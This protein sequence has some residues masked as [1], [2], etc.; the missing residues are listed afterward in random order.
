VSNRDFPHSYRPGPGPEG[1]SGGPAGRGSSFPPPPGA[2]DGY[3]RAS[4]AGGRGFGGLG[5]YGRSSGGGRSGG[6]HSARPGRGAPRGSGRLL[7]RGGPAAAEGRRGGVREDFYSPRRGAP[8]PGDGSVRGGDARGRPG[9]TRGGSSRFGTGVRDIRDELRERLRR[10]GVS[11]DWDEPGR[12]RPPRRGAAGGGGGDWDGPGG[13]EP[14]RKGSWWRHWTWKKALTVAA[15]AFGVFIILAA[16]GVAYAYSKTPIPDVQQSVNAQ[17]SKV[18]YSD[19]KTLVGQFGSTNRVILQYSQIPA[20]MVNAVV[21]AE[22]KNFWH[23]GGISPTGI[24]RAAY[25]DLTS[26]GGNLQGGSTITQQLVRNYYENIGT[27]QTLS[28]KIKEIFV[29]EKLAQ[30]KSKQWILQQYLNTVLL[31][32]NVYGVGAAAQYYFGLAPDQ[33]SKI[34]PAQAA[35]IAALIQ[36]PNG[37]SPNPK[38]GA[39]Y[40]GLVYR[41]RYVLGAMR[42]MGTLSPQEYALAA[43]K[44][45]AVVPPPN[46]TWNGYR[47]YIM[48]A[49]QNELLNTYNYSQQRINNGGLHIVTTVSKPLMGRL[50]GQVRAAETLM[51]RCTP[52]GILAGQAPAPCKGLPGYV[53]AGA[54]LED[55][56]N[57]AIL[58]WYGGPNYNKKGCHCQYDNALQS[59]NQVGSSFKTYVLATAVAQ[60]MSVQ[61]SILDGD[62][63]LWIP[64]DSQ[65]A[66]F[67]KPGGQAPGPGYYEVVND[68]SGN[69]SFGGVHV[70]LATAASLN[71]AY[72]DLWHRVA[73]N[74]TTGRHPVTDMAKA[75][76]VDVVASG[77]VGG[78]RP[79]QDEAGIALGQASLTV[80]EQATTIATLA[81]NGLY[82]SPHVIK[83]IIIGNATI[84]AK[85]TER[86]VLT[87]EQAA[88]V[89]WALSADTIAGGTAAGLGLTNG[90]PVI[91]KTGTTNLSQSAFFMAATPRYAMADALFVNRPHCPRRLGSQC[92]STASLAFQPPPGVQTLFGVGGMSGYGGQYPAYLW[93]QFFVQNFNGLPVQDFPPVNSYGQKWNL[94]GVRPKPKPKP[95]QNQGGQGCQGQGRGHGHCPHSGGPTPTPTPSIAPTGSPTPTATPTGPHFAT[96]SAPARS[97]GAGAGALALALVVVAGPSLPLVTRLRGRRS[98]TRRSAG[99]PP[100]S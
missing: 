16:A 46:N 44:F 59:R 57:G 17:A 38:A 94:Y 50:Y 30:S 82:H 2:P 67:A 89:D 75:L 68:E 49:V 84:P 80:E 41:W 98:R 81:D 61:T 22:D 43:K 99:R 55:V 58:A 96:G 7:G 64:P 88:D 65:P 15:A 36:S 5:G 39:A 100:G 31:G 71:T 74:P 91:A 53:R 3:A 97:G 19:G 9:A 11:G 79:M 12:R 8:E 42:T 40:S 45:P 66:A 87:P 29:A 48:Q 18:Y 52:P 10:N 32:G 70:Q 4:A 62:S 47:G 95:D 56:H 86:T 23:E 73:Y 28:R 27:A 83:D 13:H 37:Y 51:R 92:G 63:P 21:A 25:Y 14:R 90:Q 34:T 72:T 26:S 35:M 24:L 6:Q 33:L 77:M 93:H 85:I 78:P 69:N 54:V 60:G 1:R 20:V 76:G